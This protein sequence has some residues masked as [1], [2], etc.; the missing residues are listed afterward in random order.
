[1][2]DRLLQESPEEGLDRLTHCVHIP[3]ANGAS[4]RLRQAKTRQKRPRATPERESQEKAVDAP[5]GRGRTIVPGAALLDP[6]RRTLRPVF[7]V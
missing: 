6:P 5:G 2:I 1:M 7:A 4:F 3:R